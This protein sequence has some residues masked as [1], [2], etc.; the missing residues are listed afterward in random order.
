[1]TRGR[2]APTTFRVHPANG[3]AVK[4]FA[5]MITQWAVT[6]IST[7]DRAELIRTGLR[8][9]A[10]DRVWRG[11]GLTETP[12]DFIRIQEMEAEALAAWAERRK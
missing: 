7:M 2:P 1:L 3:P 5:G 9:E 8:Y 10:L 6:S 11:L 12:A 4:V